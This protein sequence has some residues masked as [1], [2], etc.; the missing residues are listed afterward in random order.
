MSRS[1]VCIKWKKRACLVFP[2]ES[3]KQNWMKTGGR[4]RGSAGATM[5]GEVSGLVLK[6][7]LLRK[8]GR[9]ES[10]GEKRYVRSRGQMG[11]WAL[12]AIPKGT[13]T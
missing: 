11:S 5:G 6:E 9:M 8:R 12:S 7:I 10:G 1:G 4:E 13:K 3:R 2:M